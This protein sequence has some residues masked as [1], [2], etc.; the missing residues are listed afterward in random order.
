MEQ[1]TEPCPL[2]GKE[3]D[4]WESKIKEK[5]QEEKHLKAFI[6][7]RKSIKVLSKRENQVIDCFFYKG[8]ND[9]RMIATLLKV[10]PSAIET[11]YDRAMDKLMD[12][13]FEL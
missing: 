1:K 5:K 11:Y 8:M 6:A 12:M 3:E 4:S 13:D 9:F 2:C 7:G 10:S